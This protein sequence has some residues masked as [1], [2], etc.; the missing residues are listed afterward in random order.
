MTTRRVLAWTVA[1]LSLAGCAADPDEPPIASSQQGVRCTACNTQYNGSGVHVL[2]ALPHSQFGLSDP[3][4]PWHV[5]GFKNLGGSVVATGWRGPS[6]LDSQVISAEWAGRTYQL[7]ELTVN[8]T[9][10]QVKLA[11]AAGTQI[12]NGSQL[13]D[14]LIL[15]I[16]VPD[17]ILS[18]LY[19]TR[20]LRIRG[21]SGFDRS[22]YP[23]VGG[24]S[25]YT[26]EYQR[27][28]PG[29]WDNHCGKLMTTEK[30]IFLSGS[31]WDPLDASRTDGS[32]LV[33][34]SCE[35]GAV[36]RCAMWGYPPYAK[37]D[38]QYDAAA[39]DYHQSCVYLKRA[40]YCATDK[41]ND[42]DEMPIQLADPFQFNQIDSFFDNSDHIEAL[43]GA[44]GAL[45]VTRQAIHRRNRFNNFLP[46]SPIRCL[47]ATS[48]LSALPDCTDEFMRQNPT[49][50]RSKYL[51]PIDLQIHRAAVLA[52][53]IYG[54][55]SGQF[56][57][58]TGAFTPGIANYGAEGTYQTAAV[59]R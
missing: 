4:S 9:Q 5:T 21:E 52:G 49:A 17:P 42:A 36:G 15:N 3:I 12:V 51:D 57:S 50:I 56:D 58:L 20:Q 13:G 25:G 55:P 16:R 23:N 24:I 31:H 33:T 26:V 32:N 11:S 34:L 59:Y 44:S 8:Q 53:I 1:S 28:I 46:S 48:L 29:F 18:F 6:T 30:S 45:C 40:A 43:W 19:S 10:L 22:R 54:E 27:V 37:G 7:V 47:N 14:G 2:S 38:P 35:S 39:R 41:T